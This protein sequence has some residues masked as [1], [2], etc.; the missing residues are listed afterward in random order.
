[1]AGK[2]VLIVVTTLWHL[3]LE[4]AGAAASD[5]DLYESGRDGIAVLQKI[6]LMSM[7]SIIDVMMPEMDAMRRCALSG[8]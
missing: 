5:A 2:K 1:L 7:S 8:R 4:Y 3:A 6:H